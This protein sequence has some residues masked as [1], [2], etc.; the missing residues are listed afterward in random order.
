MKKLIFLTAV[1]VSSCGFIIDKTEEKEQYRPIIHFTPEE[2]WMNDPN[3]MFY[4]EG[5]YH[6]FYQYNPFGNTWGHMSWGHAVSK[7]LIHWEHL[8]VAL[9]E[10]DGVMIFSGSA[11]VDWKNTSGFGTANNPPIVAIYTGYH[12]MTGIQEQ[13]IAFSLDKGRT[14]TKYAENPVI[15][16]KL[17]NFRDPKVI[18]YEPENKWVMVVAMPMDRNVQFY[19]SKDLKSWDLMSA[20]G[21]MGS[22]KGQ[23]ECPDLF[24]IIASDGIEKW[25]LEVDV[26]SGAPAGGSGGQYFVGSFDGTTFLSDQEVK[27][28]NKPYI[29]DG[30]LIENFENDLSNW[31][32]TGD[33]FNASP[34]SGTLPNQHEVTGYFNKKFVNSF[35]NGDQTTGEMTSKKFLINNTHINFLIGGGAHKNTA[36]NLIIDDMVVRTTSGNNSELLEW[37]HW[38]VSD[39][40][41]KEA[42]IKIT[43]NN[44]GGWG[45]I[46]VDHIH[47]SNQAAYNVTE[48]ANWVDYGKDF[49][50]GVSWSDVPKTDGRRIWLA[51]MNNWQ[52]AQ[53]IPTGKWR[54]SMSFPRTVSLLKKNENYRFQQKFV[55]ELYQVL[56]Q[57]IKLSNVSLEE[58]NAAISK[59][60]KQNK[61]SFYSSLKWE[62]DESLLLKIA[63]ENGDISFSFEYNAVERTITVLRPLAGNI[64]FHARF[65]SIQKVVVDDDIKVLDVELLVDNSSV[66]ILA[67]NGTIAFTNQIFPVDTRNILSITS[68][69]NIKIIEATFSEITE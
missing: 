8:P 34:S 12:E 62:A 55:S 49:Y 30:I 37:S 64:D 4:Y 11:V 40:L 61:L 10:E 22:V 51:W 15:D 47:L 56:D 19:S 38:N 53:E 60:V 14:W 58:I 13:S 25:I 33:A 35:Y 63:S 2:N 68:E 59:T 48:A 20:F 1:L 9:P 42:C 67:Q 24:P 29:P 66:E 46:N 50:A 27:T 26:D 54:S 41:G 57:K 52:Y 21:P 3:G 28:E 23:W 7:D 65:P 6:L 39:F 44:T 5:E 16:L 43:D 31:E 45:H 36:I 32:V 18:W 69:R 17:K